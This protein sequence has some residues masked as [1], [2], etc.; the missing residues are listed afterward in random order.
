MFMR[1]RGRTSGTRCG[2]LE[3]PSARTKMSS[4]ADFSESVQGAIERTAT[5]GAGMSCIHCVCYM[6]SGIPFLV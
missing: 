4:E 3:L 1:G 2:S 5:S 6:R